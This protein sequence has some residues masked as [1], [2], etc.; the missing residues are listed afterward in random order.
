MSCAWR[1]LEIVDIR[2]AF[3]SWVSDVLVL[4]DFRE[5]RWS[6]ED[7]VWM[8]TPLYFSNFWVMLLP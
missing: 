2:M 6:L 3:V 4:G 8:L 1:M 7:Q 5:G